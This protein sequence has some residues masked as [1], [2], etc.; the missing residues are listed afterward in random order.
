M[1][2]RNEEGRYLREVIEH[3]ATYAD[4]FV[5]IDD[6]STDE[7][8]AVCRKAV[9]SRPLTLIENGESRFANE[10]VVRTQQWGVTMSTKPDWAL[11]LDADEIFED[12]IRNQI[13]TLIDQDVADVIGFRLFDMWDPNHY[14]HDSLWCSHR[15]HRPF[16]VRSR[17]DFVFRFPNARQHC[18]RLPMNVVELPN[19]L[20]DVRL[21][22]LGWMR[23]DDRHAK[24]ERYRTLDPD[25][26][27]GSAEQYASIL[28]P[29]P[30]LVPFDE[31]E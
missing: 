19:L 8:V 6:G 9:G 13:P 25:A 7:T 3:A 31:F 21:K 1:L 29:N 10:V 26:Q 5:I 24:Y 23:P 2:V 18:G 20:S 15:F 12:R 27:F 4:D 30:H 11:F 16:L 22:H 28:N 17:P 14:R